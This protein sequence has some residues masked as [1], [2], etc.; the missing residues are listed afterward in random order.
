V[1]RDAGQIAAEVIAHLTGLVG[2]NV[3]VTLEINADIPDGVPEQ[4]V[5]IVTEN[6]RTLKF[7]SQGFETE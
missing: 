1:G 2:S 5:R 7:D 4:V 6:G 3:K